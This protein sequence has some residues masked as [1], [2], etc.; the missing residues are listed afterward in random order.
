VTQAKYYHTIVPDGGLATGNRYAE[1]FSNIELDTIFGFSA[2]FRGVNPGGGPSR[3]GFLCRG[4][5][6]RYFILVQKERSGETNIYL[7]SLRKTAIVSEKTSRE[8]FMTIFQTTVH[9]EAGVMWLPLS[10]KFG[11][12]SVY[13]QLADRSFSSRKPRD[14]DR[15]PALGLFCESGELSVKD[16]RI[17]ANDFVLDSALALP[18]IINLKMDRMFRT[19]AKKKN[20]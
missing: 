18:L 4:D 14:I 9:F 6:L 19:G 17:R 3:F 7:N 16:V 5:S 8:I 1:L 13:M 12:D 11:F 2:S 20:K 10:I 15:L